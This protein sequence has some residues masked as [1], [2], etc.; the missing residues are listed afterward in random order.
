MKTPKPKLWGIYREPGAQAHRRR[1]EVGRV[2]GLMTSSPRPRR[3]AVIEAAS[4]HEA[5]EAFV[6]AEQV[7][8]SAVQGWHIAKGR[9]V[10][11]LTNG[12]S[13]HEAIYQAWRQP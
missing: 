5:L 3:Q 6:K 13:V 9:L 1:R 2:Y 10:V 12:R 7:R 8:S 4:E 11:T